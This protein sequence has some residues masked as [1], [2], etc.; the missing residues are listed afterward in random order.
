MKIEAVIA[1]LGLCGASMAVCAHDDSQGSMVLPSIDVTGGQIVSPYRAEAASTATKTNIPLKDVPQTVNVVPSELIKDQNMTSLQDVMRNVPGVSADAGDGQRDQFVIR[2]FSA[3]ND[4]YLDGMRDD[5]YY[6]RDLS[7]I[8]RVEIL[9]GPASVLY[10]RGSSGG[11]I[12]RVTKKPEADPVQ[13]ISLQG[14]TEGQKRTELDVGGVNDNDSIRVRL[15]GALEDSDGFRDHYF[16]K[17]QAFS[18][19]IQFN[20][21]PD[22]TLLVQA[23]Y[24]HDNRLAD[25]GLP[26]YGDHPVDADIDTYYGSK[27]ARGQNNVDTTVK[28]TT[29]TLDHTLSDSLSFHS[30]ARVYESSVV[31][32]YATF[33]SVSTSTDTVRMNRAARYKDEKGVFWQ[34]ELQQTFDTGF[35]NHQVLYGLELGYQNKKDEGLTLRNAATYNIFDPQLIDFPSIPSTTASNPDADTDISIAGLY[36]QDLITINPQWKLMVGGRFDRLGTKR[37]DDGTANLD[38]DRTDNTFSPRIGLVY[39]PID[40]V[41]LYATYSRSF[42]P[43]ADNGELRVNADQLKPEETTNKEVGAKFDLA[44]GLAMT[45]SVFDMK[46]TGILM[47]D[48]TDTRFSVDAGTQRTK[49]L[50]LSMS[51]DLGDGWSAYAGYAWLKGEMVSSPV[52]AIVGNTSALTP[53]NSGNIWLKKDL[54]SGFYVAGGA[55]YEGERYT[56]PN[57]VVSLGSY[58]T[59]Q[60]AGGYR[61][62]HY[63]VTLDIE[64]L[65]NREY[66]VSAKSGSDNSNYPGAPRYASL[67]VDYRF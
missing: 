59:A 10:G 33:A 6:Y 27:D 4:M 29:F 19:S 32:K 53:K 64:N 42:Q 25:T 44:N 36:L 13:Q 21:S 26:A 35:L 61:S 39:E 46:R 16:L 30:S 43:L 3:L 31:R 20:L 8:D 58:T 34:N 17:R 2:G 7:N 63:D 52:A 49:G 24:L 5:A 67:R 15:T 55:R 48:P 50:E 37:S 22:T 23:D 45:V 18:P 47:D 28:G 41:S 65:F 57:N 62:Q 12:N 11:L 56:S 38:L 40:W 1:T 54:G 51:G 9:K 60:L 14:S 66:F